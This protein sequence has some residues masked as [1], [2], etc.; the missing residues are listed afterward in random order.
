MGVV[1]GRQVRVLSWYPQ[2]DRRLRKQRTCYV[3]SVRFRF[4]EDNW[5]RLQR[6]QWTEDRTGGASSR[7]GARVAPLDGCWTSRVGLMRKHVNGR[8]GPCCSLRWLRWSRLEAEDGMTERKVVRA[9]WGGEE[10]LGKDQVVI[11]VGRRRKNL[12]RILMPLVS[13]RARQQRRHRHE[14]QQYWYR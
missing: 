7:L 10:R 14:L 1:V 2:S 13:S 6:Q 4:D 5:N 8:E 9:S 12:G 11:R 3:G